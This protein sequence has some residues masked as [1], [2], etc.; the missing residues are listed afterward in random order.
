MGWKVFIWLSPENAYRE[1]KHSDYIVME[2]N[3]STQTHRVFI[4][5]CFLCYTYLCKQGWQ[6]E[7][8]RAKVIA[9]DILFTV[10]IYVSVIRL[11]L[12]LR[13]LCGQS[14]KRSDLWSYLPVDSSHYSWPSC[15][16][17]NIAN[18]NNLTI[19]VVHKEC[20]ALLR[21]G[22]LILRAIIVSIRY[23]SQRLNGAVS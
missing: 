14:C 2:N 16:R 1:A 10:D 6:R 11:A 19:N 20:P 5:L 4:R 12:I 7:T 13:C 21:A 15:K 17:E 3:H 23:K 9:L 22:K 8:E 18:Q